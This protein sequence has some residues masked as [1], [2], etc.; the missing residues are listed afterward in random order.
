ML[1]SGVCFMTTLWRTCCVVYVL[2]MIGLW[3]RGVKYLAKIRNGIKPPT[4][5]IRVWSHVLIAWHLCWIPPAWLGLAP[6]REDDGQGAQRS[7]PLTTVHLCWWSAQGHCPQSQPCLAEQGTAE[8]LEL[9]MHSITLSFPLQCFI[10]RKFKHTEK[11]AVFYGEYLYTPPRL[12]RLGFT[13]LILSHIHP[14]IHF[15]SPSI[16]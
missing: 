1:W 3:H 12:F 11:Q 15:L 10:I 9:G 2:R 6:L 5:E 13:I 14:S 16:K 8:C 4:Q 7:S